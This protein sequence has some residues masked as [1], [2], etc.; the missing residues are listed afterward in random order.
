MAE[1]PFIKVAE[2]PNQTIY[3][4]RTAG[5]GV[6][7]YSDQYGAECLIVDMTT[8]DEFTLKMILQLH[9]HLE[10]KSWNSTGT[11]YDVMEM[12]ERAKQE[13][14]KTPKAGRID[15]MG[16]CIKCGIV[17]PTESVRLGMINP[18]ECDFYGCPQKD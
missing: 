9:K 18:P 16:R 17:Q 4:K 7:Y 15:R 12:K 10:Q 2:L 1:Y 3:A 13:A 11:R 6:A 8:T 5:G 14:A